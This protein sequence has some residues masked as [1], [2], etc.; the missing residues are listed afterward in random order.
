MTVENFGLWR[1]AEEENDLS[2]ASKTLP[3]CDLLDFPL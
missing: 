1:F 3:E 2:P